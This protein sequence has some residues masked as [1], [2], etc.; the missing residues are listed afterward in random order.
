MRNITSF[1][2]N[3]ED[4]KSESNLIKNKIR[5]LNPNIFHFNLQSSFIYE[6]IYSYIYYN[7]LSNKNC[8]KLSND[9]INKLELIFKSLPQNE[10]KTI[11]VL[12]FF[13][14][15]MDNVAKIKPNLNERDLILKTIIET[16]PN[17]QNISLQK[18]TKKFNDIAENK[19]LLKIKKSTIHKIMRKK[20]LMRFRKKTVKNQKLISF[21]Y[22]K[23]SFFFIKIFVRAISLGLKFVFIDESGFLLN[24]NNYRNWVFNGQEIYYNFSSSKRINLILAVSD[25]KVLNYQINEENTNSTIFKNFM[26]QLLEKMGEEEKNQH[27]FIMDNFA[28][29]L[30]PEL[31]EFYR[32]N[33]IKV[34]FGVP[35]A[36]QYNMVENVFRLIKN[37]TY[38]KLY[39]SIELLITDINEILNDNK[40]L[41]SLK[42]LFNETVGEYLK[43]IQDNK[44]INLNEQ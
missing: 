18:I 38:K 11:F 43:F 33:K 35:Y 28:G 44:H 3:A 27:V 1:S 14:A 41:L 30:T 37:K 5:K 13:K 21:N 19:G 20:L 17:N 8:M 42:K 2:L 15:I 10:D 34:L 12:P 23:Y 39:K 31:F 9:E 22:I 7:N 16:F 40:T 6:P 29:H 4:N 25:T 32:A 24:N 36:S 26:I